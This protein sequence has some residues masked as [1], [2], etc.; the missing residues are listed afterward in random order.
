MLESQV[1]ENAH[2]MRDPA[3][4][5]DSQSVIIFVSQSTACG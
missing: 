3:D 5:H 1:E 4:D 2:L